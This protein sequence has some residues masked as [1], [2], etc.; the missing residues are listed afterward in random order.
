[1]KDVTIV[2]RIGFNP[3]YSSVTGFQS[4]LNIKPIPNSLKAGNEPTTNEP[5][6]LAKSAKTRRAKNRL[7][8]LKRASC[9][10]L[11]ELRS[12]VAI[13]SAASLIF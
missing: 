2:P 11:F 1:M 4:V 7:A 9:I 6:M 12:E 5:I 8:P 13:S 3:P 10:L